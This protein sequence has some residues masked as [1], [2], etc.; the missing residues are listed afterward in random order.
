MM[1]ELVGA[2]AGA[3]ASF[4]T[5]LAIGLPPIQREKPR[6]R[7]WEVSAAFPTPVIGAG[8]TVAVC[9]ALGWKELRLAVLVGVAVGVASAAFV[10]NIERVFP[11]PEPG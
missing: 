9:R 10:A 7:S 2:A 8:G 1:V 4:I 11:R 6:R 3:A 5:A